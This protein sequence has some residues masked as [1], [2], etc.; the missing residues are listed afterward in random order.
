MSINSISNSSLQQILSSQLS[1]EQ[2][3]LAQL[4]EQLA[5][6]QQQSNLTDYS[7]S[8]ALN[9]MNLQNSATQRQAY[10]SVINTVQT[11]LTGYDNT[12]TDM[13]FVVTQAQSLANGN[14][15]FSASEAPSIAAAAN[16][17]LNP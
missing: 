4:T 16:N 8:D 14:P 6:G 9:L 17:F 3:N 1:T 2:T 12:M 15:S 5:T 13:E 7:P 11:R 10:I